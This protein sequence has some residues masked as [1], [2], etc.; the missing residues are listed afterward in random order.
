M[1]PQVLEIVQHAVAALPLDEPFDVVGRFAALVPVT[2]LAVLLGIPASGVPQVRAWA[3]RLARFMGDP[4][5]SLDLAL[6]AQ[7]AV[8]EARTAVER[9][10]EQDVEGVIGRLTRLRRAGAP[11]TDDEFHATI[12][13]LLVGGHRTTAAGI[14]SSIL[15]LARDPAGRAELRSE[16]STTKAVVEELLRYESPHQ[17]TVRIVRR[18]M[19][20]GGTDLREGDVVML[21]NG[22]ANRDDRRFVRADELDLRRDARRHLAFSAGIHFCTGASLARLELS[23]ALRAFL[24]RYPDYHLAREP[25]WLDNRTL[26]SLTELWVAPGRADESLP[27]TTPASSGTRS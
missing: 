25:R 12:I 18:P 21:M 23:A 6:D 9:L 2:V 26:R 3:D 14:A 5:P 1:E 16:P 22:S 13:V 11:I 8:L 15:A 4:R 10:V 24:D 7:A 17:R 19:T 20:L 27:A